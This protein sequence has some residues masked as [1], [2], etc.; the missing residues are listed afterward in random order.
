VKTALKALPQN[1]AEREKTL[2]KKLVATARQKA[3][4]E[5]ENWQPL[6]G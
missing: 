1:I 3:R 5:L 2:A 6:A 4:N